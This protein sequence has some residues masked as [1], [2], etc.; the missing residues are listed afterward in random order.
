MAFLK[1]MTY[2]NYYISYVY[3]LS[4]SDLHFSFNVAHIPMIERHD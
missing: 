3:A 4:I 2:I 1:D